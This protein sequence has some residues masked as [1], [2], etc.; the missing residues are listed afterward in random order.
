V[1]KSAFLGMSSEGPTLNPCLRG[2]ELK[3]IHRFAGQVEISPIPFS[4]NILSN[5][6]SF[7]SGATISVRCGLG[8]FVTHPHCLAEPHRWGQSTSI[9]QLGGW[10]K[11]SISVR[12]GYVSGNMELSEILQE[13]GLMEKLRANHATQTLFQT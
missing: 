10:P 9:P 8:S 4:K 11:I 12:R 2:W 5:T 6:A 3:V 13:S 7:P 1:C